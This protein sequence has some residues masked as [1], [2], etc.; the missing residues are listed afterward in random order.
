VPSVC[1]PRLRQAGWTPQGDH[2][3]TEQDSFTDGRIV[4]ARNTTNRQ[5]KKRTDYLLRYTR[6]FPI[7]VVE[8]KRDYK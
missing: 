2:S 4:V 6:D 1:R 3:F 5:R 7:A 8:A